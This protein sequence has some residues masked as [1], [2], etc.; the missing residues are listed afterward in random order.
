VVEKENYSI[1]IYLLFH[2]EG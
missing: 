2:L 1:F